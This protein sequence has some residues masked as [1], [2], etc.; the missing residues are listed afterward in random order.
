MAH[1]KPIP[2]KICEFCSCEYEP[3]KFHLSGPKKG[4]SAG[5]SQTRFCSGEC[6]NR[7]RARGWLDKHGY[8]MLSKGKRGS[9]AQ[10]EHRKVMEEVLGR[11]LTKSET[12]HHKNGIRSDNRPE[13]L[14]LWA[15]R[16]GKGQRVSDLLIADPRDYI[17]GALSLAA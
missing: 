5:R 9:Y 14:E 8:R 15:S 12:V 1:R 10:P 4:H 17:L 16:H 2:M 7:A 6:R 11:P 3:R 13:N